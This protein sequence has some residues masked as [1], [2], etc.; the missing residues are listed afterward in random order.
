MGYCLV[1][2]LCRFALIAAWLSFLFSSFICQALRKSSPLTSVFN[3]RVPLIE[4]V[5]MLESIL[6]CIFV[7]KKWT[8]NSPYSCGELS[9]KQCFSWPD[10]AADMTNPAKAIPNQVY[11]YVLYIGAPHLRRNDPLDSQ[12]GPH[13]IV[14]LIFFNRFSVL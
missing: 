13:D 2:L 6:T 4:H 1:F 7:T 9:I 5:P 3:L 10:H 8:I 11:I 12:N 14:E